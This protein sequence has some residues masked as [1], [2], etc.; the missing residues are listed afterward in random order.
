MQKNKDRQAAL[1]RR[2]L[3]K[4][5]IPVQSYIH[6]SRKKELKDFAETLKDPKK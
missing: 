5:L 6:K 1:R 4:G 2:R 3:E